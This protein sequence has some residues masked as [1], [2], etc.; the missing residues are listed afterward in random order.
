MNILQQTKPDDWS[1]VFNKLED[2]LK[3]DKQLN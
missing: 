2:L 3:N 1:S